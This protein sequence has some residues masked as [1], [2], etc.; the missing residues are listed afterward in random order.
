MQQGQDAALAAN[1]Q[2]RAQVTQL[3]GQLAAAQ[4]VAPPAPTVDAASAER[5]A[6]DAERRAAEAQLLVDAAE[7]RMHAVDMRL[8]A[9]GDTQARILENET[10]PTEF[11][12]LTI[13]ALHKF[14]GQLNHSQ[15]SPEERIS[16]TASALDAARLQ[17]KHLVHLI[18]Q[19]VVTALHK[20][21]TMLYHAHRVVAF[22]G[23]EHHSAVDDATAAVATAQAP[24]QAAE[25]AAKEFVQKK[26]EWLT[27][28]LAKLQSSQ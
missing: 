1:A 19:P 11:A 27:T 4:R 18:P 28:R 10:G 13:D 23:A 5:R 7:R 21:Q 3:V 17:L 9:H 20:A 24:Y 8:I 26:I 6:A 14:A 15:Y 12:F 2:L 25:N 16:F 22:S